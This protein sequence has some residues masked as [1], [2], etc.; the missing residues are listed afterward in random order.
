MQ[1]VD[2]H[3]FL[4]KQFV[5][6]HLSPFI[7]ILDEADVGLSRSEKGISSYQPTSTANVYV[8]AKKQS[9]FLDSQWGHLVASLSE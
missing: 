3:T 4:P 8:G 9:R 1:A 2:N 5:G 6:L 7:P